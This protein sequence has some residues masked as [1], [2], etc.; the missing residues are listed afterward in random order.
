M[1]ERWFTENHE[2]LEI[3]AGLVTLGVTDFA[4][5]QLGDIVFV[6][7]PEEGAAMAAGEDVIVIESVK[8]AGEV[9]SP[10][11]G[12][13]EEVNEVLADA[14]ETINEDPLGAG[15]MIK[16]RTDGVPDLSS[17]MDETAYAAFIEDH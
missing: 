15:W 13:V 9:S 7:L 4:Q 8:A 11:S 2:W 17:F 14:P 12:V 16:L 6:E 3:D 1:S 10:L 5:S